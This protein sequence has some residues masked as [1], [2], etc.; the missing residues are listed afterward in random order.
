MFVLSCRREGDVTI[1]MLMYDNTR[2]AVV[3]GQVVTATV[4]VLTLIPPRYVLK[5]FC[6]K[7]SD[8]GLLA[9]K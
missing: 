1:I 9:N 6:Y 3:S 5:V 4:T 7:M 8:Q 2:A